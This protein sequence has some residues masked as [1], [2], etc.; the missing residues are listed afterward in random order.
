MKVIKTGDTTWENRHET[1]VENI[2]DL[3]ELGNDD[4]MDALNSYNDATK[5]F[6]NLISQAIAT[7]TPLRALGSAWSWPKIATV[8]NGI[9]LDTKPLNTIFDITANSVSSSYAGDP[10]YLV[11]AQS[12]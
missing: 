7:Q 2:K 11:F 5:G 4:A 9:M 3:Y 6:Q 12:G 8:A 10:K 1:F